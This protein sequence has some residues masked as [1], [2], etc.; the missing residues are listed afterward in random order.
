MSDTLRQA[1]AKARLQPVDV[2]SALGVDPKT[3]A[4][5]LKGRVPYPRHRWA[6]ADLLQLDEGDLWPDVAQPRRTISHEVKA[7]YPHRWAVPQTIWRQL[8]QGATREIDILTYSSLFL[9][10]DTGM[11]HLLASRAPAGVKVRIL[12]GDPDSPE[13]AARGVEEGIG[14]DVMAA[15]VR[16]ALMLYRPLREVDGVEIRLHRTVLYN[17]IYRADAELLVN[18]HAYSVPAAQAPVLYLTATKDEDSTAVYLI[19][20]ERVWATAEPLR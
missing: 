14:A 11:I 17:S 8:F 19:S 12:L 15:R 4:R 10:E 2:A 20:L 7:V 9:A 1:L 18:V 6:L 16:N 3:V 13:V 5:W